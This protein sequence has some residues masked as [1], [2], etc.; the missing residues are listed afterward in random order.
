MNFACIWITTLFM[1][2]LAV[3]QDQSIRGFSAVS[4]RD[5]AGFEQKARAIPDG[6]RMAKYMD[7]IAAQPHQAG[8]PRSK[9]VAQYIQGLLTE[10]GLDAQ[11]ERFDVLLPYPTVRLV[12]VLSP[13]RYVA[14]LKE[15]VV[16]QDQNSGDKNQL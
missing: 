7:F 1:A 8:S 11:L 16:P 10:W 6:A 3:A 13:K 14:K 2:T 5:E 15:P 4:S 9:Q 12:E